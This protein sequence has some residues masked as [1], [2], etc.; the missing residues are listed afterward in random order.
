MLRIKM[1]ETD[2]RQ[3]MMPDVLSKT[4]NRKQVDT[5]R[6]GGKENQS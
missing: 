6:S 3:I 1:Y 4:G 2:S 5:R